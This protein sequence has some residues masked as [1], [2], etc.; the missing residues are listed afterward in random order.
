[1]LAFAK[2]RVDSDHV[3]QGG[4]LATYIK[5]LARHAPA[6]CAWPSNKQSG[7]ICG[8]V[9]LTACCCAQGKAPDEGRNDHALLRAG[10]E[11]T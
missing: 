2:C 1:M 7:R 6:S 4:D 11:S 10:S 5:A 8:L 9:C 3:Q